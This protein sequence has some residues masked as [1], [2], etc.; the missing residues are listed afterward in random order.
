MNAPIF[1]LLF[2]ALGAAGA[3][4]QTRAVHE[5]KSWKFSRADHPA[6]AQPDF[7]DADWETVA[8]P[9]DWAIYGPFDEE[10][11][12]QTVRIEQNNEL[13]ATEKT[14]RTGA[15]AVHRGWLV[16]HQPGAARADGR[17]TGAA[18]LR[19][20]DEQCRSLCEWRKSRRA[21]LRLQLLLFRHHQPPEA[22]CA[23][24]DRRALGKL[25]VLLP[26]VPR[27]G[28]VPQ[29]AADRQRPGELPALGA[30]YH[31]ALYFGK[32]GESEHPLAS[33]GGRLAG[34]GDHPGPRGAGRGG[35][36]RH[37]C[38]LATR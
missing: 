37:P 10:I 12:K 17:E 20:R 21:A 16:P 7:N 14:G 23:Q 24:L 6:A 33:A 29:G 19:W 11:D 26:L 30:F 25:A 28:L 2:L 13:V 31:H 32:R 36:P 15:L 34:G 1:P 5:L 9:H 38:A 35:K 22:R 27:R 18:G 4:A 8:V 3:T